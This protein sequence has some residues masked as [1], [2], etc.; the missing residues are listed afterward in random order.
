MVWSL[1]P[2]MAFLAGFLLVS[3]KIITVW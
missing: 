2:V 3:V 1:E